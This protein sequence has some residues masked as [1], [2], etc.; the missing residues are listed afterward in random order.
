MKNMEEEGN[1]LDYLYVL[2]KWRR[3]IVLAVLAV[4]L[5][6]AGISLILPKAWTATTTLLP[7][8]KASNPFAASTLLSMAVP[9]NLAGLVGDVPSEQL[10][11]ILKS[12]RV[13]GA[14]VDR[15]GLVQEFE[16]ASRDRAMDLLEQQVEEDLRT[17]GTLV[18]AVTASS[19]SLA[20][21]LAN[22]MAAELDLVN[23][24]RKSQEARALRRF[25]QERLQALELEFRESG[26]AM[27]R[28]Q[29]TYGLIDLEEQTAAAVEVA[30]HIVLELALLEVKLGV[31]TRQLGPQHE[32]QRLLRLEVEELRRQLQALHGNFQ[33]RAGKA[34]ET[35]LRS[36]GPSL[37]DLPELGFEYARLSLDI[38][39]KEQ[40]ISYL[41]TRFEEAKYREALD[42]PTIQVLD[43]ATPP[44]TRSAPRRTVLVLVA[45]AVALVV[46]V[47]L[48]FVFESAGRLRS[49]NREKI[50]EIKQVWNPGSRGKSN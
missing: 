46:S 1:L 32:N 35:A 48:A 14:I 11:T 49:R 25:L 31:A 30:R 29:E 42:T 34:A 3:M 9:G 26:R 17:D 27:R 36:L 16:A 45:A 38:K 20:A 22:A 10:V 21:E 33:D 13:L 8:E 24:E 7:P 6:T 4:S 47:V 44:E 18:I 50:E 41:G 12:K 43:A 15:F 40:I 37:K 5:A 39:I 28:F 2:V 23:R 19:P